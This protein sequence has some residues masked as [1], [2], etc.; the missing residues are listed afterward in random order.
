MKKI[1][2][3]DQYNASGGAQTILVN[4][5]RFALDLG[6]DV[7]VWLPNGYYIQSQFVDE[8]RVHFKRI[9]S[10]TLP[11]DRRSFINHLYWVFYSV[12]F[13]RHLPKL[14]KVDFIYVNGPRLSLATIMIS[15]F[16]PA[17]FYYHLHLLHSKI[18]NLIFKLAMIMP[19]TKYLFFASDY[20]L[21]NF[22]GHK[23]NKRAVIY[24]GFLSSQFS[25]LSYVNRFNV[26]HSDQV[27]GLNIMLLARV[28]KGKGHDLFLKL[29]ADFPHHKF[30]IIGNAADP[31]Y[32]DML[33][34]RATKNVVFTCTDNVP[35]LIEQLG[36][37]I[38]ITPSL[39]AESFGL[40]PIES[41]SMSCLSIVS[42]KGNLPFQAEKTGSWVFSDYEDLMKMISRIE[43]MDAVALQKITQE[44]YDSTRG[45]YAID[46]AKEFFGKHVC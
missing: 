41:M 30:Y 9:H 36:I 13:I 4:L 46:M 27:I 5:I 1:V 31:N 7:E 42:D 8:S 35:A 44:Q 40:S 34:S 43:R 20:L 10:P 6:Y 15:L 21:H 26:L 2:F 19:R 39:V 32:Y 29:A 14:K 38:S 16:Y 37:H 45:Y 11:F 33:K 23:K 12:F 22:D 3:L 17:K 28:Y 25:A 24:N 18:E